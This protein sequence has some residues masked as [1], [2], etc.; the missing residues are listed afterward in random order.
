MHVKKAEGNGMANQE[1]LDLLKQGGDTW[2]K[3]R[4]EHI[5]IRPNLSRA[6][7]RGAILCG[8]KLSLANLYGAELSLAN[9]SEANLSGLHVLRPKGLP[10]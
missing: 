4:E 8:A 10:L 2:N 5:Y 1:H 6:N 7:L 9:L 3:W